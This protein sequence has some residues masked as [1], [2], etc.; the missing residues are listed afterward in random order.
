M[1]TTQLRELEQ[2]GIVSR[3]VFA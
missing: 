1:L 2:D 3:T